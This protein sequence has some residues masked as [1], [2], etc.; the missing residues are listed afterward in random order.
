MR[1]MVVRRP[2]RTVFMAAS[3]SI[4]AGMSMVPV[5]NRRAI[6]PSIFPTFGSPLLSASFSCHDFFV[7]IGGLRDLFRQSLFCLACHEARPAERSVDAPFVFSPNFANELKVEQAAQVGAN[8]V[9]MQPRR[10]LF[11]LF[12]C[13]A[14]QRQPL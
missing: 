10:A 6:L 8:F 3:T 4:G 11:G 12:V 7:A 2:R 9:L 1:S 5:P 13:I 14:G